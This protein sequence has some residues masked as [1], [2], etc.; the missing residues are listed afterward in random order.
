MLESEY[1]SFEPILGMM[2]EGEQRGHLTRF[3]LLN[4]GF[5]GSGSERQKY[6]GVKN[7]HQSKIPV[8]LVE[9]PSSGG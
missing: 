5:T 7:E 3:H 6:N 9:A 2:V 4:A 1:T 8:K